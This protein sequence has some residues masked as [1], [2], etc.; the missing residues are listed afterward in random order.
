MP[1]LV[2][3]QADA[4]ADLRDRYR[5]TLREGVDYS[6]QVLTQLESL[7][8]QSPVPHAEALQR[9]V[10]PLPTP[11]P[12]QYT[13]EELT[14]ATMDPW[15][16]QVSDALQLVGEAGGA[17]LGTLTAPV[18]G[19][20][21]PAVGAGLGQYGA[22]R[23][24]QALGMEKGMP[25]LIP[26]TGYE[27]ALLG[28][29]M[30]AALPQVGKGLVAKAQQTVQQV[31]RGFPRALQGGGLAGEWGNLG[32]VPVAKGQVLPETVVR[33]RLYHGTQRSYPDFS[34][35]EAA[36][37]SLYGPGIYLTDDPR[38]A[39]GDPAQGM[40]GYAGTLAERQQRVQRLEE[41]V[42]PWRDKAAYAR[43]Q[44]K[45]VQGQL[46][47]E[48]DPAVQARMHA[49]MTQYQQDLDAA[50]DQLL[51]AQHWQRQAEREGPNV[52]PVYADLRN[53]FDMDA[54]VPEAQIR[55]LFAQTPGAQHESVDNMLAGAMRREGTQPMLQPMT[56]NDVYELLTVRGFGGDKERVNHFLQQAGYD[57]ITHIGGRLTG[58]PPHRV[59]IAFSEDSVY[60]AP[61]V[62]ATRAQVRTAPP[63]EPWQG[64]NPLHLR[65]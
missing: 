13:P 10:A 22:Y 29:P 32:P 48:T 7:L 62:E 51:D 31:A 12:R 61:N 27:W 6:T 25:M 16:K 59:V 49:R 38:I 55:A 36:P 56:G 18:T 3:Q 35:E 58:H 60:P 24:A 45:L 26:Q 23:A 1:P 44:L 8:R 65:D 2:T 57:G 9:P 37:T 39:G 20:V 19:P 34:V 43:T 41:A 11:L 15:Q 17:A 33:T 30:L 4:H 21:G 40:R 52:R 50:L 47:Q 42:G 46:A 5:Q 28:V 54:V 14:Q 64:G 53:P 63:E